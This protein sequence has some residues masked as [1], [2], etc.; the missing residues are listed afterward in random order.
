MWGM[1]IWRVA[2]E[3]APAPRCACPSRALAPA[4]EDGDGAGEK[5]P[6]L[7]AGVGCGLWISITLTEKC[8]L[9]GN[10][11]MMRFFSYICIPM[12]LKAIACRVT[13]TR[14]GET[15]ELDCTGS[16]K[17]VVM[18]ANLISFNFSLRV[19]TETERPSCVHALP[20]KLQFA[21]QPKLALNP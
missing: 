7:L 16:A 13:D 18:G 8:S 1:G 14:Y 10:R 17:S 12:K 21:G 3:D 15:K 6:S 2:A 11:S 19:K 20:K 4:E 5:L 9:L